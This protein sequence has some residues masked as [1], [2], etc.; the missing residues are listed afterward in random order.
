MNNLFSL[1]SVRVFLIGGSI[2]LASCRPSSERMPAPVPGPMP[3]PLFYASFNEGLVADKAPGDP[4]FY[5]SPS[6]RDSVQEEVRG[7]AYVEWV[8]E[9]GIQG[10]ALRFSS[11]WDPVLFYEGAENIP[12]TSSLSFSFWL[13]A[14]PVAGL[15]EGY[16]DPFLITD[17]NWDDASFYVDF[18]DVVPRDF[19]FAAFSNKGIWNPENTSWDALPVEDRPM[20]A[21]SDPPFSAEAWTHV[22]LVVEGLND[23]S[24]PA[25]IMGYLNGKAAGTRQFDRLQMDWEPARLRMML[26]RHFNG[27]F[28]ELKVFDESLDTAHVEMLFAE[29]EGQ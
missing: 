25:R 20:V 15:A 12:A 2:L 14:D 10:G 29:L 1:R 19:R 11:L 9:G 22:V 26:G 28:D 17:K 16:S 8:E 3:E 13:K 24:G 6:L 21:V 27:F 4:L 7:S 18:T 5:T 23:P